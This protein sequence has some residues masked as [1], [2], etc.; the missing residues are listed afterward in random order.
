MLKFKDNK[1]EKE[2]HKEYY[3]SVFLMRISLFFGILLFS[4]FGILDI[5]LAPS[6]KEIIWFI[7]FA[8]IIPIT[9]ITFILTFISLFRKY[10]QVI[11]TVSAIL[12]GYGIIAMIVIS[13]ENELGYTLYYIGLIIVLMWIFMLVRLRFYY[14][15]AAAL[16][17]IL[18]YEFVAIFIQKMTDG[19]LDGNR[20]PIFLSNNFYFISAGIVGSYSCYTIENLNRR[21][22]IQKR[23][24]SHQAM[25]DS[26]TD[27]YNHKTIIGFLDKGIKLCQRYNLN[28]SLLMLDID[29]FKRVNDTYGHQT[30]DKVI[31][32]TAETIKATLRDTDIVGRYGGEEFMVIL[33]ETDFDSCLNTATRIRENISKLT[34]SEGFAIT[35]SGGCKQWTNETPKDLISEVDQLLYHAKENGRDRIN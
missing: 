16:F 3:N 2:F 18:G 14:A 19:G 5:W 27:F 23:T 24:I 1:I 4:V 33:P 21:D 10:M 32:K 31:I 12:R 20:L 35:I 30:G 28:L 17:I 7:R 34:F 29:H 22:F 9:L 25:C 15:C 13:K 26:M 6:S 8:I 11:L